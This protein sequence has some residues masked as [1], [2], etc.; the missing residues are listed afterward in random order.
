MSVEISFPNVNNKKA[1]RLAVDLQTHL[2]HQLSRNDQTAE[3]DFK[4]SDPSSMDLGTI[5]TIVLGAE[6]IVVLAN[7]VR[8][9]IQLNNGVEINVNGVVIKDLKSEHV[10]EAIEAIMRD[11]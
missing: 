6:A 4:R 10:A 7:A 2:K 1:R 11:S 9:W 3:F 5:L 8:D